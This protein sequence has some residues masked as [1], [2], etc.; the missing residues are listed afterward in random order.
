MVRRLVAGSALVWLATMAVPARADDAEEERLARE[1][2]ELTGATR[3]SKQ[4]MEGLMA[5]FA[6]NP[7]IPQAFRDRFLE[8]ADPD[9]L[10][11]MT[12]PIYVDVYDEDT[13]RAAV[14]FYRTDAGTRLVEGLPEVT[15]RAMEA[16]KTWGQ[17][18]AQQVLTEMQAQAQA[19]AA[20][21]A[22][23][24]AEAAPEEPAPKGKKDKKR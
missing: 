18:L 7:T 21:Q 24:A 12:V 8:L 15:G 1:L 17:Q 4:V 6:A 16:G 10:V 22:A 5:Q 14:E 11:E 19:E 13:L 2:M 20:A 9:Q 3:T 23:A